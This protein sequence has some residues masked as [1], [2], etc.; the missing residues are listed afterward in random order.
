MGALCATVLFLTF[1]PLHYG[2]LLPLDH[3]QAMEL[4]AESRFFSRWLSESRYQKSRTI[5]K[6]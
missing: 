1:H 3:A 5:R 4:A 6:L 2:K